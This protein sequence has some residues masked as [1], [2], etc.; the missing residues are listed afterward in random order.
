MASLNYFISLK[1]TPPCL[2]GSKAWRSSFG[3][4]V[5]GPARA[6]F[7]PSARVFVA[8]LAAPTVVAG[9][10]FFHSPTLCLKSP[11]FKS[12]LS[13][14]VTC[15]NST[16]NITVNVI[17]SNSIG[18]RQSSGSAWQGAQRRSVKWK[19]RSSNVLMTSL[20][21]TFGGE[22]SAFDSYLPSS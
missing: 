6:T 1:T 12:W 8:P 17:S 18:E 19:G 16:Q 9:E 14:A 4:A 11:S 10:F 15:A 21:F 3:S 7:S 22:S 13:L 2:V 5:C 20:S